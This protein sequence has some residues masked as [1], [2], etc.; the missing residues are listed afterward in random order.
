M[1][2]DSPVKKKQ[3][4]AT[5]TLYKY[6]GYRIHCTGRKANRRMAQSQTKY[7]GHRLR[8]V[9][10]K[11]LHVGLKTKVVAADFNAGLVRSPAHARNGLKTGT[12]AATKRLSFF[13]YPYLSMRVTVSHAKGKV[14]LFVGYFC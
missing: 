12:L 6:Y 8:M 4:S 5:D 9:S 2:L 10:L 13:K 11:T 7:L 14:R 1:K 3:V